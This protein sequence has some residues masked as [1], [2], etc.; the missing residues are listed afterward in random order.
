MNEVRSRNVSLGCG[1]LI[2]IALIVL[3]FSRGGTEELRQDIRNLDY[4]IRKL[5]DSVDSQ[6]GEI[7]ALRQ[8]LEAAGSPAPPA[9]P[10]AEAEEKR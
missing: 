6:A 5:K 7:E 1:T 8:K 10:K 2:L 9:P 3:I 4:S